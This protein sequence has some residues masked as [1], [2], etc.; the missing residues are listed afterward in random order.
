MKRSLILVL[1]LLVLLPLAVFATGTKEAAP[2]AGTQASSKITT[3][4]VTLTIWVELNTAELSYYANLAETPGAKEI[5]KR[6]G[7]D[8]KFQHPP[9]GQAAEAFNIMVAGGDLPDIVANYFY[10]QYK[11]GVK[12]AIADGVIIDVKDLVDKYAPIFKK[13]VLGND[14]SRKIV[15]D[16]DGVLTGFGGGVAFDLKF[17][18]GHIYVG[19]M[20]RKDLLAKSG[21]PSPV[22]M[23]DWY[24]LLTK[25]KEMGVKIPLAWGHNSKDWDPGYYMNTWALPYDT[26]FNHR[27]QKGFYDNKGKIEYGPTNAGYKAMLTTLNKWYTEG[28]ISKDMPTQTY[29]EHVKYQSST[30]EAGSAVQHLFEYGTINQT[31]VEKGFEFVPT[32]LPVVKKGQKLKWKDEGGG[33]PSENGWYIT[34]KCKHPVEAVKLIDY[35]YSNEAKLIENWG[36]EGESYVMKN[37]LP[38]FSDKFLADRVR[39][40]MLY[41]PNAIKLNLDSRMDDMQYSL[42]VQREAWAVWG[43]KDVYDPAYSWKFK[44]GKTFTS[45]EDARYNAI[46]TDIWT[47]AEEMF[48]KYILGRESLST[49]DAYVAKIQGMGLKEAQAIQQSALDAYNKR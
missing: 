2:A 15:I 22:T 46:M 14:I 27:L 1:A 23:D 9:A 13:M 25:F 8:L 34:T 36:I 32:A 24:K 21:L 40:N 11:G 16:R 6:T 48:L 28:L 3:E 37:G 35:L 29:L 17:G 38:E 44:T 41:A 47:Y 49:Y 5:M 30:G 26:M 18:E 33:T 4:P 39:M 42:P 20:V 31:L 45:E 12:Q 7:L 43:G 10:D 19:P